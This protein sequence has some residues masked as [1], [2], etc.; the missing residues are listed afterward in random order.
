MPAAQTSTPHPGIQGTFATSACARA[1]LL[2]PLSLLLC[3]DG[4]F[5]YQPAAG[6]EA[7]WSLELAV[8]LACESF[9]GTVDGQELPIE[10]LPSILRPDQLQLNLPLRWAFT[11]RNFEALEGRLMAFERVLGPFR[12]GPLEIEQIG[13]VQSGQRLAYRRADP[14]ADFAV[15][16]LSADDEDLGSPAL[17]GLFAPRPMAA[18]LDTDLPTEPG[19]ALRLEL[20]ALRALG[21]L[22][23]GFNA[24]ALNELGSDLSLDP[25]AAAFVSGLAEQM[26]NALEEGQ[27]TWTADEAAVEDD[28]QDGQLAGELTLL[29]DLSRGFEHLAEEA[30]G[31][32]QAAEDISALLRVEIEVD[33]A[34]TLDL[35][36]QVPVD[37][38][39]ELPTR[40]LLEVSAI[41][42]ESGQALPVTA[43]W[44]LAGDLRLTGN[45]D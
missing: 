11:E 10:E 42:L 8:E 18:W 24:G 20:D 17:L 37:F 4:G 33:G 5:R 35:G 7:E 9:T 39:L 27:L 16:L 30:L 31:S 36:R 2:G 29:F 44:E 13:A 15:R 34:A 14:A 40:L 21:L 23:P 41:V 6:D 28:Q 25:L 19:S 43:R 45:I 12:V 26:E 22:L 3:A 1:L 38:D 32:G